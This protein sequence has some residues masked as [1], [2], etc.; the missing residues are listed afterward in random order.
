MNA[1]DDLIIGRT[2]CGLEQFQRRIT[3]P[4]LYSADR[5]DRIRSMSAAVAEE[6]PAVKPL[7]DG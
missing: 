3:K 1:D 5:P 7:P 4:L 6:S 2:R